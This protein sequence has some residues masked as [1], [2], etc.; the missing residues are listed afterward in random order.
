MGGGGFACACA[1]VLVSKHVHE[2]PKTYSAILHK[3][4]AQLF[5]GVWGMALLEISFGCKI[6]TIS[7]S[8]SLY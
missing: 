4:F 7:E 5:L 2:L 8:T 1:C 6:K 3:Q